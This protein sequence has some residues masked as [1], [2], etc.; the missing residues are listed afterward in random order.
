MGGD[1]RTTLSGVVASLEAE[2]RMRMATVSPL[3]SLLMVRWRLFSSSGVRTRPRTGTAAPPSEILG[4]RHHT[5]EAV[6]LAFPATT[7]HWRASRKR[8][9]G[10]H[11]HVRDFDL[12]VIDW[13]V[14][15]LFSALQMPPSMTLRPAPSNNRSKFAKR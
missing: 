8:L 13:L 2:Y 5:G 7:F 6:E 15:L 10:E 11:L 1:V 3:N 9:S 14:E 4:E 12:I